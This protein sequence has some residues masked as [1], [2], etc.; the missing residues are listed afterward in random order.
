[1]SRRQRVAAVSKVR[2]LEHQ[3]FDGERVN[4]SLSRQAAERLVVQI[5]ELRRLLGWLEVDVEGH[6]RW[7][8][9]QQKVAAGGH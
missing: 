1:M 6:W 8:H 3:L 7:P 2:C 4:R 9:E 5:N